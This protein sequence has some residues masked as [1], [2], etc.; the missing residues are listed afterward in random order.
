MK[1]LN[2]TDT[3]I[4]GRI[5]SFSHQNEAGYFRALCETIQEIRETRS[6]NAKI[7]VCTEY[8]T[9]LERDEDLNLAA[10][11][12]GEGAFDPISSKRSSVGS[13]TSATA[14]AEF[15]EVDYEMVFKPCRA[16]TGSNSETIEKLMANLDTA[17]NKRNPELIPLSEVDRIFKELAQ[18]SGRAEKQEI[19]VQSWKKMTPVEIK[20]FMR[21]LGRGSLRIGFEAHSVVSSIAKAFNKKPA[22]VRY[23]HMITGSIGKT[24]VLAKN[25]KLDEAEFRLF[26]PIPFMLASAIEKQITFDL[27]GY[28]AEDKFDGMRCQVHVDGNTVRLYSRDLNDITKSFPEIIEFFIRKNL[29]PAILDGE[30]CVFKNETIQ[31]SQFLQKRMGSKKT[32]MEVRKEFPVLFI[33]YDLLYTDGFPVFDKTLADRR[34]LLEAF[35]ADYQLP[36]SRQIDVR[37]SEHV[38]KLVKRAVAHGNEGLMLKKKVSKYEYGER[39]KSWLK[40]KKPRGSLTVVIMYAHAPSD[41]KGETLSDFT[42]GISVRD[43]ERYEENFIPIGKACSGYSDDELTEIN[44]KVKELT[45]E[46]Y[47]P[48][49]GLI[50]E[51]IVEIEFD[52]IQPNPRTKAGYT[53]K[54][55]RFKAI[56]RDLSSDDTATLKDVERLYQQKIDRKRLKQDKNQSFFFAGPMYIDT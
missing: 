26:H 20:Y 15:C 1:D 50:P 39:R 21:M 24:A 16:A 31:P 23:V 19:L 32:G 40:V 27:S 54:L 51:L 10:R 3:E 47:G 42:L 34:K 6:V 56:R 22:V 12:I 49:L 13:R 44:K 35:T 46:R 8:F 2:K 18:V 11:F 17:Q 53:L 48:T 4:T 52:D 45:V 9:R 30:I 5:P 29:P 37:S 55:P 14:A 38:E 7:A 41:K 36:I 43:D 25:A 33:A 28:I